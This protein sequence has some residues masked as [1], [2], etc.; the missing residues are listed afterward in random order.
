MI[1]NKRFLLISFLVLSLVLTACSP[2]DSDNT[3]EVHHGNGEGMDHGDGKDGEDHHGEYE[4]GEVEMDKQENRVH[5]EQIAATPPESLNENATIG[6]SVTNTKNVTRL[7]EDDPVA[8]SIQAS[9]TVWPA[10][11]ETNQPGTI[12]LAP[13]NQWQYALA[14]LTLVHHPNDGPMLYWEKEISDDVLTELSRLQPKGNNEGVQVLVL[15][16]ID[17]KELNKL[18]DYN[19]EQIKGENPADFAKKVEERFSETI[20]GIQPNVIIGSSEENAKE[21]T[22]TVANWITHMNESLLYVNNEGI[23]QETIDALKSRDDGVTIYIIGPEEVISE[24]VADELETYGTV[25][26]IEGKDPVAQSI[27]FASFKDAETGFGWGITNPGHGFVFSSTGTPELAIAAAPFAHL[28]KHAPLIWLD[29]GEVTSELYEY[30]ASVKPAF[31]EEPTEGPYN[32]G[33]VVG[34]F[35]H[36]SFATQGILDEKMEIVSLGGDDHGGH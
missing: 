25:H 7:N 8:L 30:M 11:H 23:P 20:S 31:I 35:N 4:S 17:D 2:E 10:T 3:E 32:H 24:D 15:G 12:I 36:V 34:S 28:G 29:E 9:Q 1:V 26:R 14:S 22:I 6:L 18:D 33:Y 27:E 19:V 5:L 21:Y 13:L 16:D